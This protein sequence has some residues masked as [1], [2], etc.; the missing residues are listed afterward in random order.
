M[1]NDT[2]PEHASPIE[3]TAQRRAD[4]IRAIS[5]AYPP[6][7][8]WWSAGI[9]YAPGPNP[10]PEGGSHTLYDTTAGD[11]CKQLAAALGRKGV[12]L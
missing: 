4:L 6:Y 10:G 7:R 9:Y 12:E 5:R 2:A 1:A 3:F 11:L 8:V